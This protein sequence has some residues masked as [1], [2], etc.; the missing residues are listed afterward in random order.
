MTHVMGCWH[1]FETG[2]LEF[3]TFYTNANSKSVKY[4]FHFGKLCPDIILTM[5]ENPMMPHRTFTPAPN[6]QFWEM[7][8]SG[9]IHF[10]ISQEMGIVVGYL[11]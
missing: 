11:T 5:H 3:Q 4:T 2:W 8:T 1:T 10:V 9:G 6:D 7:S